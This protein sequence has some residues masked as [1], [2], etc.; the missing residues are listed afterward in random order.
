M[1][2]KILFFGFSVTR[3][4]NPPYPTR[5]IEILAEQGNDDYEISYAA[6]GGV[7]LE[8]I[9]FITEHLKK[10]SPDLIF[11]EIA[12]SHYALTKKDIERTKDIFLR[13]F[14]NLALFCKKIVFLLL[15]RRDIEGMCPIRVALDQLR[16]EYSFGLI[17]MRDAF[18]S[19][20]DLYAVDA[21]HPSRLGIEKICEEI[22]RYLAM[23][24]V[25][26]L[27]INTRIGNFRELALSNF[28]QHHKYPLLRSFEHTNFSV[29][30]VPMAA[31]DILE[32][33]LDRNSYLHGI[34]Y[35]MGPET[36]SLDIR[37]LDKALSIRTFDQHSYYYRIGF[38]PFQESKQVR[39]NEAI[40]IVSSENRFDTILT[41]DSVY[42]T[43]GI[44]NYPIS[45]ACSD[46]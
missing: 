40:E 41:K 13:L 20:W 2:K 24:E 3:Y 9:P 8:C 36:S 11:F 18:D 4:G 15:P 44:M 28:A 29:K 42:K 1:K 14:D 37:F 26:D 10:L 39:K 17:E 32:L 30:A 7:S 46:A 5:L 23:G 19:E 6:L 16:T 45:F 22:K 27:N 35:L 38:T 31:S 43:Y 34:F 25:L 33:R 12:T 21:V